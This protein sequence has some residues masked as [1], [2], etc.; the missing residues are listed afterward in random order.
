VVT[1][2]PDV[3]TTVVQPEG[4]RTPATAKHAVAVIVEEVA[5]DEVTV[6]AIVMVQLTCCPAPVGYAGGSHW[7]AAGATA[8]GVAAAALEIP[9]EPAIN[10]LPNAVQATTS[11]KRP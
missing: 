4:G 3:V 1:S 6:L 5:P 7:V 9:A 11:T 2:W 10:K 8:A